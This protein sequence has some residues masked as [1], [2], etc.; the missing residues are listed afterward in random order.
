MTKTALPSAFAEK[1]L[2]FATL[3]ETQNLSH[4]VEKLGIS[5]QSIRRHIRELESIR[6][7]PFFE[8]SPPRYRLTEAGKD[9]ARAAADM[10]QQMQKW[11]CGEPVLPYELQKSSL[12]INDDLWMYTQ[13]HHYL[14]L[15]D[16]APP[17]IV[18][19]A[20]ALTA[21]GGHI[22]HESMCKIRPY[23]IAARRYR[24]EWVITEIGDKSAFTSW[25]GAGAAN[26]ELG[27][28][29]SMGTT[30]DPIVS[31]W[32]RDYMIAFKTGSPMYHH[33]CHRSTP[34][35]D[36]PSRPVN[37]QRLISACKFADGE[38][39]LVSVVARTNRIEIPH[40][41]PEKFVPLTEQYIMEYEP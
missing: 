28:R 38:L 4:A 1:L 29:P 32:Q 2:S 41:P 36:A 27:R 21:A 19:A 37:Y 35:Y 17:L 12:E 31:G 39:A 7:D 33:L 24:G 8:A 20:T 30:Y 40:M 3:A 25:Y 6:G 13:Q 26:S 11:M 15:W 23:I 16:M 14:S 34:K 22:D 18:H 10:V 5:R 9:A